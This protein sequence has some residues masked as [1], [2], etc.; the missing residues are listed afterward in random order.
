MDATKTPQALRD[1]I[2][3]GRTSIGI[4]LGSTR[5]KAVLVGEDH[6]PLAAGTYDWEN[7]Y[8]NG[9]WTYPLAQVEE[10]MRAAFA[11]LAADVRAKH[12][13]ALRTTAS[14]GIS[15]MMHGYLAFDADGALLVPFRTWRNNRTEAASV[16]L[17]ELF[18]YP[19]PQRWSI[20]HLRQAV[21]DREPHVP[22][23]ARLTT[24]AGYVHGRLTGRNA[25]GVGEASGMFPID[26]ATKDYDAGRLAKFDA[27]VAP[28]GYPWKLREILPD[29]LPAGADAGALTADG[30]R[31]L[32]PTGT[33]AAGIP[34]CPP[35]GDAG[36]GMVATN[37]VRPRTGN[38]SA[39]TS[40]FAMIVL[41]KALAKAHPEIDLATTPAG[42]LVAMVHSSNCTSDYDAWLRLFAEALIALDLR[43]PKA[44]LYDTLL[45]LALEGD[46][47]AGGLVSYGYLAGEHL[48]HFSEGRPLF[49]RT[50]DAKFDLRN[51]MRVQLYASLGA[52][53][54]GLDILFGEEGVRIDE[55]RGHGGFFKAAKVG[56]AMMAAAT[57]V[58]VSV[59]STA[60]EGGAWG[61]A[62]LASYRVRRADGEGLADF[63]DRRAFAGLAT[64]VVQPD[65]LDVAGY[66]A[67]LARYRAGLAVERAAVDVLK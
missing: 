10:G 46:P 27:L 61:A 22:R 4:E 34:L 53:R 7:A 6:A 18:G 64:T 33:L 1:A 54:T 41:E 15:G 23:I 29:V 14:I 45:G 36:T 62:L 5:I 65:P 49:V 17:T 25:L 44:T 16:E 31:W 13:T 3:A 63:L 48:T 51:F 52:L 12:G 21:L 40:V 8:E 30:A 35:E 19:I 28:Q 67:F 66:D 24:L 59:L 20:A 55:L 60:G 37:A 9:W 50:P 26:L 2:D 47:D 32:D 57:G 42:D 58:P 11:S 43:V 38:V 39:G 56:Q